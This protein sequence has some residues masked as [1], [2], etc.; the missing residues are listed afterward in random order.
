MSDTLQSILGVVSV[1]AIGGVAGGLVWLL[2]WAGSAFAKK[3]AANKL[4]LAAVKV[5]EL[6][7]AIVRDIEATVKP[8]ASRMTADGKLTPEE[9]KRLRDLA[10]A[11][12]KTSLGERGLEQLRGTLGLAGV[13]AE[14]YLAGKVEEAVATV[15]APQA[16]VAAVV[17][18]AR[19]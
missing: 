5:A 19:P 6:A 11:R 10:L 16:A 15:K 4:W 3:A 18:G 9:A 12:L 13:A 7:S 1:L 8:E 14:G 17:S 2:A